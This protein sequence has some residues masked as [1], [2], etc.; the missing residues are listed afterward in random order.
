LY[1]EDVNLSPLVEAIVSLANIRRV[2]CSNYDDVLEEGYTRLGTGYR[3]LVPGDDIPLDGDEVLIVHPHGFLPRA[4]YS[5]DYRMEPIVLSEDDYH[6]LYAS[7][8]R[9][10]NVIQLNLFVSFAVLFV[11]C[12]LKDPNL[13]RLLDTS[14]KLRISNHFALMREPTYQSDKGKTSSH[15]RKQPRWW[16]EMWS[17]FYKKVATENLVDRGITPIWYKQHSDVPRI[18][19]E[20]A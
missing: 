11:G 10:A 13:R 7:P 15:Q 17:S 3:P 12:S 2:C 19:R 9:W 5:R 18:L 20:I 4:A 6:D 14:K 8:Y 1:S 16:E